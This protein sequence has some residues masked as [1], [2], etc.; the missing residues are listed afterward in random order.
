MKISIAMT[1]YNGELYLLNQLESFIF[2]T[3][4]PDELVICDDGSVDGT[5][6]IIENFS[7]KAPFPVRVYRNS[8]RLG[9]SKN[10]GRAIE[11]CKG[12][13]IA[14]S[15]QDDVWFSN[16]LEKIEETFRSKSNPGYVFSDALV[17]DEKLK[18]LGYT[19]WERISFKGH[20]YAMFKRGR[21]MEVLL[22][23]NVVT[24]ATMA[25][26]KDVVE[27]ILP[28]PENWFHDA[29][30]AFL[31]TALGRGGEAIDQCLIK[32]RQHDAQVVGGR[33]RNFW[34]QLKYS[35]ENVPNDCAV[36]MTRL[37][38]ARDRLLSIPSSAQGCIDEISDKISH[39]EMRRKLHGMSLVTKIFYILNECAH[40][41]YRRYSNGV[42]SAM[43]DL[44]LNDRSNAE[45]K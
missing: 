31:I 21:Q 29:W 27:C 39:L 32:Y 18:P 9:P 12:E 2:Q 3:R 20:R 10:F 22:N 44:M 35:R 34:C 11:F 15:D 13:I 28:I 24:G 42:Y 43:V 1:T 38:V 4:Q 37:L 17:V 6:E 7:K 41:R 26:R 45:V 30:I 33:K 8:K 36:A 19:M 14:L 40:G 16:K 5:I 25:I 23:R